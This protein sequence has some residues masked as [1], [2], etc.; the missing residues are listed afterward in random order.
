VTTTSLAALPDLRRR[1]WR[2][3]ALWMAVV[4]LFVGG[5]NMALPDFAWA[6][7]VQV[8]HGVYIDV[9]MVICYLALMAGSGTLGG[10][11]KPA[12]ARRFAQLV[13]GLAGLGIVSAGFNP[14][15]LYDL[16]QAMRLLLFAA[17]VPLAVH[18]CRVWSSALV[19]RC[20]LLGAA[21]GGLINFYF[22]FTQP[23]VLVGLLP[24]LRSQNGA[25]G[26][27][28]I[29]ILLAA[30]LMLVR[31][32]PADVA[33]AI[34][35]SVLGLVAAAVSFSKTSMT[36]AAC[37]IVAWVFVLGG[38]VARRR[39]RLIGLATVVLVVSA[40][41]Y[42][43]RSVEATTYR[44]AVIRAVTL[45]FTGL[46]VKNRYSLGTRYMY[47]WGVAEIV[48]RHPV[49][50]V[51]YSGFY[52]AVIQTATYQ[53]GSMAQESPESGSQGAS[54]PHNTLLYYASANG[55]PGFLLVTVIFVTF[56]GYAWRSLAEHGLSGR[57]VAVALAGGYFLYGMT[58]PDLL[59]TPVFYWPA[60]VAI[61]ESMRWRATMSARAAGVTATA[62]VPASARVVGK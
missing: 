20:Y 31:R 26:L 18:W 25:G 49:V 33:V 15:R 50:G 56:L 30:W 46:S 4:I 19:L 54:N 23:E 10:V 8:V 60:A 47:F 9:A 62:M 61:A 2:Q 17:T 48:A 36:I 12:E 53:T 6:R 34:G 28:G 1:P 52:D 11:F 45:K 27:L 3:P 43:G 42:T 57:G 55:L 21:T 58:L 14:Y 44:T 37:G 13:A 22:S 41:A 35:V 59:E 24:V 38:T 7:P 5:Y 29:A 32:S 39:L 16:G 40:V 51:S